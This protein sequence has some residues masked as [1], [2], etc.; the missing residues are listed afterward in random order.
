MAENEEP[1]EQPSNLLWAID[2]IIIALQRFRE[3]LMRLAAE[4]KNT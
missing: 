1:A 2:E 3:R 4:G